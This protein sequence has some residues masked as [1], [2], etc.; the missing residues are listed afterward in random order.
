MLAPGNRLGAYEITAKLGEGGMGVV[1]RARDSK[2]ERDVAIKVL[3]AAFLQDPERLARFEREAKLLAQLH[4]PNI[5]AI[6]GLE[7]SGGTR[8][9]VMELVEGPTLAERLERGALPVEDA[10]AVARQIA[11]ALEEAHEKGIVHRD[12]K[13]QNVKLT[14]DGRVKVLDFGLAKA[15]DP[16][17]SASGPLANSPTLLN[18]PT[19]TSAGT[20]LGVI[21]GTAA[22]M[23]PE[24]AKGGAVDRRADI[25]AFGVVLFEMLSGQRLFAGDSVAE[26][27]A[28]VL[29]SEIPVEKLPAETPRAVGELVRH[30][31]VKDPRH[32]L[33]SIGDAR[34]A[35]EETT[36][37]VGLPA[38]EP[39]RT[40]SR[41]RW[42]LVVVGLAAL[43]IGAV[44]G[45]RLGHGVGARPSPQLEFR[46]LTFQPGLEWAG[47]LS[48]DGRTLFFE[49]RTA[50]KLPAPGAPAGATLHGE[51][52]SVP[53]GGKRPVLLTPDT[54]E[55]NDDPRLSPDGT[56]LAFT[57]TRGGGGIFLMGVNGESVR[58]LT[59]TGFNPAWS[60]DGRAIAFSTAGFFVPWDRGTQGELRIVDVASGATRKL[61]TGDAVQP[62]W[63]PSGR[64]IAYWGLRPGSGNREIWTVGADGGEPVA[65]GGA[66]GVS[67][68]PVWSEDGRYLYFLSDRGGTMNRWRVA[69]DE[70]SGR[71]LGEPESLPLPAEE[72]LYLARVGPRWVYSAYSS[73]S[74]LKSWSF[75]AE[76]ALLVGAPRLVVSSTGGIR[77]M[78]ASPDDRTLAFS[79]V[80]PQQDLYVVD[81]GGGTPTQLTDDPEKDRFP[82][83]SPDGKEIVF[84]S[85]RGPRYEFWGIH[86]D[87]SGLRQLTQTDAEA[88]W[89]PLLSPR[90]DRLAASS[91]KGVSIF[92]ARGPAPWKQFE[93]LPNP[94]GTHGEVFAALAWSP[95][96]KLLAGVSGSDTAPNRVA[97]YDL[98]SRGYHVLELTS[99]AVGWYPDSRRLLILIDGR[100]AVLDLATWKTTPVAQSPSFAGFVT[101]SRDLRTIY[102]LEDDEEGDVWLAE[103]PTAAKQP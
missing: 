100:L 8:A 71:A 75:D 69:I 49:A 7:E 41:G 60:P 14:P 68:N 82:S 5:A 52:Y 78:E 79:T 36:S 67:W 103:E 94:P 90:G 99:T 85:Q 37:G 28:A 101:A 59:D 48:A 53:V 70:A 6:F 61:A 47:D 32:R 21:L 93:R 18:S 2:L 57:S 87:G 62:A 74:S 56:H 11:E 43:A 25:W 73:R 26:T 1:Y 95:D 98:S 55:D 3:P 76:R 44:A 97:I 83:W 42:P 9:R 22:Y 38:A 33:Q 80:M 24:Q 86:P 19:L 66:K 40:A 77:S 81:A 45:S 15:L 65:V 46:K 10:L 12:L 63:S 13:P 51:I 50:G 54:S 102:F 23:S 72:V 89:G 64:R 39:E 17:A 88:M 4:H 58:R 35:L 96:G 31:L 34:V 20:Q 27:L 30:C 29:R 91:D 84:M 92:D 16:A